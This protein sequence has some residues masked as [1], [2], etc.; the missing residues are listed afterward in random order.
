MYYVYAL[1]SKKYNRIYIGFSK[2]IKKRL[3]KH[4]QGNVYSTKRMGELE[5]VFYEAMISKKDAL[6]REKYLKTTKGKRAL[7][8]MLKD[9]LKP[10]PIV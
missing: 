3:H 2:Q 10:A 4:K 8:I 7:K 6:R 9:T 1:K 5:L